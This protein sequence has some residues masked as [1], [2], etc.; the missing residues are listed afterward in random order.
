MGSSAY[1]NFVTGDQEEKVEETIALTKGQYQQL[2]SL[3]KQKETVTVMPSV[4][5]IQSVFTPTTLGNAH[6]ANMFGISLSLSTSTHKVLNPLQIPW[7]IDTGAT[8]HMVCNTS[9]LT[10][11]TSEVSYSVKLPNGNQVPVTHLGTVKLTDKLILTNVVCVPSFTFNLL[12]VKKLANS[13]ICCLVFLSNC[14]FLQDLLSW[15]TI[16]MGEVRNGLYH[17]Q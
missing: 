13:L 17:L 12:S 2:L 6:A 7:I 1:V 8:D 3:L 14:C 9:L 5:Q 16:G 4:N 15:T 10:T 11:I